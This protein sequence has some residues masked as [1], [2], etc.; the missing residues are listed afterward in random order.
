ME[1]DS[2]DFNK[3]DIIYISR[4]PESIQ[5][6]N[7]SCK[8]RYFSPSEVSCPHC[9]QLNSLSSIIGKVRPII[10]WKTQTYWYRSM[11][12]AIPVSSTQPMLETLYDE[13]IKLEHYS[14]QHL[15]PRKHIP[16]RAVISQSTRIDGNVLNLANKIGS[17]TDKTV[18]S[19]IENK[20]WDWLF[21][22]S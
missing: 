18:Q 8:G 15:D 4:F 14:F 5:C 21:T 22:D 1:F 9:N 20:L 17:L 3:W 16:M 13:P 12:F 7:E 11:S 2:P 6:V 10:L 19:K